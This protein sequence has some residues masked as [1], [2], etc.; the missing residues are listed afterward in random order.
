MVRSLDNIRYEKNWRLY[1]LKNNKR[2]DFLGSENVVWSYCGVINGDWILNYS[3]WKSIIIFV[4]IK[5][6]GQKGIASQI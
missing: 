1:F 6:K 5:Q 2:P 3:T 4:S